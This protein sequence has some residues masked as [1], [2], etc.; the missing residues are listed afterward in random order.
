[1]RI[2]SSNW[3][4]TFV[5][6]ALCLGV[7]A[8]MAA[9]HRQYLQPEDFAPFHARV[10][11]QIDALP[12]AIDSWVGARAE[13]PAAAQ[14]LLRPNALRAIRYSDMTPEHLAAG[15]PR[16]VLLVFVQCQR[17]ADMVGHFPPNCYP[18]QG[19]EQV[20]ARAR[21]WEIASR[22]LPGTEY[23]FTRSLDRQS[24]KTIVYNFM[25][26][27]RQGIYRDINGVQQAA[28]DYQQRY[29]G[30]AQVQVVFTGPSAELSES[31]R[32]E[33]FSTLLRPAMGAI[34]TLISGAI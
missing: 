1:M 13:V 10:K 14:L 2:R 3:L 9:Q 33:I 29:F 19:F 12:T 17:A 18:S 27:P 22:P 20:A 30:A 6:P 34:E 32:D 25:V 31:E 5:A 15:S 24:L 23:V 16:T 26:V 28:E 4:G 21:D 11:Q 8:G 7:L